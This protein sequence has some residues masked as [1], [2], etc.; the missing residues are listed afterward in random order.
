MSGNKSA[1]ENRA[2]DTDFR[3]TWD[4]DEYA[5]KA[6]KERDEAKEDAQARHEAKLQG[7]K[8]HKHVD[9]S[10]LDA[11]SARSSRLD[12]ASLVGKSTIVPAGAGV[13]KRGKGAGFYCEACDLTFKDNVQYIE[14]L[15]SKQHLIATGQS[16]EVKRAT[17]QDVKDRIDMLIQRKRDREEEEQHLGETDVTARINRLKEEDDAERAEKR[18]K[19]NEQRQK[20]K[21]AVKEEDD[22][23]ND[24]LGIIA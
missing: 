21:A 14:H 19:R 2:S 18:R 15:N 24:R 17:L 20:Q 3:R 22:W 1:Y 10:A 11:T 13:G 5:A 8:W 4:R 12:V 16:G 7:K 6:K 23:M 9:T